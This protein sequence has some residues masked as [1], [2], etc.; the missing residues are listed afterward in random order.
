[1]PCTL[2]T[3]LSL[4]L[5]IIIYLETK[6]FWLALSGCKIVRRLNSVLWERCCGLGHTRR[7]DNLVLFFFNCVRLHDD[8]W[9]SG[10]CYLFTFYYYIV[11]LRISVIVNNDFVISTYFH[12]V[13]SGRSSLRC[14]AAQFICWAALWLKCSTYCGLCCWDCCWYL[15]T[16]LRVLRSLDL[17]L[18]WQPSKSATVLHVSTWF[19]KYCWIIF[20]GFGLWKTSDN[21]TFLD[22]DKNKDH[23]CY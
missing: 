16:M 7:L 1:M 5:E 11:M 21:P 19:E 8:E 14:V 3:Y 13:L 23:F 22:K 9:F 18:I 17:L 6:M 12:R 10:L 2:I 4:L 15:I 20:V